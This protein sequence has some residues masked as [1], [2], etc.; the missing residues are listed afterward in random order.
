MDNLFEKGKFWVDSIFDVGNEYSKA[1]VIP[2]INSKYFP[3]SHTRTILFPTKYLEFSFF[4]SRS[5]SHRLPEFQR[6]EFKGCLIQGQYYDMNHWERGTPGRRSDCYDMEGIDLVS[7]MKESPVR[8]K[9]EGEL[10]SPE[11]L[12]SGRSR[13]NEQCRLYCFNVGQGDSSLLIVNGNAYLIDTNIYSGVVLNRF[14]NKLREILYEEGILSGI[15]ALIIT[16]KH[17][18]HLRGAHRFIASGAIPV[19]HLVMNHKY[20]HATK[21]VAD[22][23]KSAEEN[24]RPNGWI[25]ASRPFNINEGIFKLDFLNPTRATNSI[26]KAPDINDSSIVFTVYDTR[27]PQGCR[28]VLTGDASFPILEKCLPKT[29]ATCSILKVSHHGSRT[30]TSVKLMRLINP[31]YASISVGNSRKYNHPHKE[32]KK[33]L[34]TALGCRPVHIS[35]EHRGTVRYDLGLLNFRLLP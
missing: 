9:T 1:L 22:F 18:D 10:N 7:G 28:F 24:I 21:C 34:K 11:V 33:I 26:E 6:D 25:D 14:I 12:N 13:G 17:L 19:H 29:S 23:I 16:H 2:D 4:M 30:G 31:Y 27:E 32:S 5:E 3:P 15:K 20:R 8:D 35:K